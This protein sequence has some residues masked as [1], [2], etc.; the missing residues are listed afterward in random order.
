MMLLSQWVKV[1]LF[2]E[3]KR[4]GN[5]VLHLSGVYF[6]FTKG[7]TAQI[8]FIFSHE[9]T[10]SFKPIFCRKKRGPSMGTLRK[11]IVETSP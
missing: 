4:K 2:V 5:I 10:K 11:C 9:S 6:R 7:T 8:F 3:G 1:V